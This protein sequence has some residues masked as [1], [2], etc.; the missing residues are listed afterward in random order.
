[1]YLKNRS[2]LRFILLATYYM[3]IVF[4][5]KPILFSIPIYIIFYYYVLCFTTAGYHNIRIKKNIYSIAM[6]MITRHLPTLIN[7]TFSYHL[8]PV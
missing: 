8:L 5:V 4:Y 2:S 3:S 1:M 7:T 6:S